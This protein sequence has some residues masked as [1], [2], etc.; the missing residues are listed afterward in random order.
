MRSVE[1]RKQ[2]ELRNQLFGLAQL[3]AVAVAMYDEAVRHATEK[4]VRTAFQDFQADHRQHLTELPKAIQHVGWATPEFKLD[5]KGHLEEWI[6]ALRC[7]GGTSGALHAMWTA[8]KHHN[9]AYGRALDWDLDDLELSEL[10]RD[11]HNHE[12]RHLAY[13]EQEIH[14]LSV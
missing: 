13:V 14:Q 11:F 8:E 1:H 10:L 2:L 7:V 3:D 5:L 4:Q 12:S 9:K 6:V